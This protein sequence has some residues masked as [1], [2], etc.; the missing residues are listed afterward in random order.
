MKV[1]IF[2]TPNVSEESEG[3]SQSKSIERYKQEIANLKAIIQS[4][5]KGQGS[6]STTDQEPLGDGYGYEI[7]RSL[8]NEVAELR[9]ENHALAQKLS[10]RLRELNSST[11]ALNR[12]TK[13]VFGPSFFTLQPAVPNQPTADYPVTEHEE[14]SEKESELKS[15]STMLMDKLTF[16]NSLDSQMR[17]LEVLYSELDTRGQHVADMQLVQE[18]RWQS[19]MKFHSWLQS[20]AQIR[21]QRDGATASS[22]GRGRL[23]DVEEDEDD[24]AQRVALLETSVLFQSEE[25]QRAKAS[26]IKVT[27]SITSV[28]RFFND[29]AIFADKQSTQRGVA[30]GATGDMSAAKS[31]S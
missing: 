31:V 15:Q 9:A 11:N 4:L 20:Q 17:S 7:E 26:F 2:A 12:L 5:A 14:E 22:G 1:Q 28:S 24:T 18:E 25:L 6:A 3:G 27:N 21:R 19:L 23:T 8:A 13:A 10:I 16:D 29:F 30:G